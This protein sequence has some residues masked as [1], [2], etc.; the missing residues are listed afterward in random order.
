VEE[1]HDD[2]FAFLSWDEVRSLAKMGFDVG[3]HSVDHPILTQLDNRQLRF[4][5]R[6]SKATIEREL[7]SECICFAYPNGGVLDFSEDVVDGVRQAG[8]RIAFTGIGQ[9][10]L[11]SQDPLLLGRIGIPGNITIAAFETVVSGLY[12]MLRG[13]L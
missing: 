4:Q 13:L 6:D 10:S 8:Y 11:R 9:F 5:V 12:A 2:L 7:A 3:S 1:D